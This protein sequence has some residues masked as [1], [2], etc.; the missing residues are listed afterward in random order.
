MHK[1]LAAYAMAEVLLL[2]GM[3]LAQSHAMYR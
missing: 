1:G 2:Q 3:A